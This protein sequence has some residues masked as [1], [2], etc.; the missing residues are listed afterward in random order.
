[1]AGTIKG[2]TI[3]IEG[4]T[5]GLTKSLQE[6]E[7]QIKKD[8]AAL[9]NLEKAL[10]LDPTNVDLLAAKEAVLA[11]KTEAVTKK[12]D[13]LKQV[14]SDALTELPDDAQLTSS[15]MAELATEIAMTEATLND[16]SGASE[17]ASEDMADVGDSAEETGE[18]VEDSS[19]SFSDFGD[20]AE[21]AGEMAAAAMD[22][23]V[24]AVE[25]VVAAA[26][27]AG[28][29]IGAAFVEAGSALVDATFNT[30]Q[31]AD[32]LLTL[33][34]TT[35]L[36]TDTLQELNYA[37]ELL[38]V[39]TQ[40]VTGSMTKLLKTMGNAADG[41]SSAAAK[42][43]EL[44]IAYLDSEGNM[45][46]VEDVFWESIDALGQIENESERDA[47]AMELFGRS[48]RE[49]NPLIEAGSGAFEELAEE[50]NE[51][52]YVMSGETLDAFGELDDNMQ[53][54]NNM[55]DAVS[56]SFGQ[57]L[58]PILSD[59]SGEAV[60]L[61]GDFSGALAATGGD[62]DQIASVIETFAPR[63]VELVEKYIPQIIKIVE[64]VA[65]AILPVI[66]SLAPQLIAML[67]NLITTLANS[68]ADNAE[69]FISAF[70]IL[71]ESVVNSV[72]TLLPVL[73]PLAIDLIM[74][75]VNALIDNA[76]LL[77]EGALGIVMTLCE[78]LLAPEN[79]EQLAM[80]AIEI[81][82]TL[83]NGLTTA[84]PVLIPAALDAI[85][86]LVETL[87]SGDSLSQLIGAA[88]TLITTLA[89]SLI[90]YLPE[91]IARLPEII[92]GIVE[93]LCGDGLQ[94]II[95]AGF[96]L[97][98]ALITNLDDIIVAIVGGLIELVAGMVEYFTGDG[99]D[100]LIK[101]GQTMFDGLINLA[102][103]WGSDLIQQFIDGI[104]AMWESLKGT[105]NSVAELVKNIL[106][107]SVPE[108][109]PLH[110]WAFNN[111]GE[112]M[113]KLWSEG[114][115]NGMSDLQN[116]LNNAALTIDDEMSGLDNSYEVVKRSDIRQTVDYSGGLS[117]IEQAITASVASNGAGLE[118]VTLVI[119]V[120][121]GGDLIDTVVV[122]S[123]DRYNYRAGGRS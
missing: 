38:D 81:V 119:P 121:L 3:Q 51:V 108:E 89:T 91:L 117:R 102:S 20:A 23:V 46:S 6:V 9:K 103:S 60:S 1:M 15:Q 75:L 72:I 13:I 95:E 32:E 62:I 47:A 39:D 8:D 36:S 24:V 111:P 85:M 48:A 90:D 35:G 25:A 45:R 12:M 98:T 54:L 53:R 57:I 101:A 18:D 68:I 44:G 22:A 34:S 42:F 94:Q 43:E 76:P 7:S 97:I 92:L 114:V 58:L 87:L 61:M 64:Q 4:K 96:T 27:A 100:D 99:M 67:G 88:L 104:M 65:N 11:D 120:Y 109:G 28:A 30:S 31:L 74:T 10:Q 78:T 69:S 29:A 118:G 106:G 73:I 2:I 66:I 56:N 122:D 17:E 93:Y 50:A 37:S 14:Q 52:G 49:L 80:S 84:L 115:E 55:T 107:F 83:L 77:L 5:S 21:V 19:D 16:L 71:F 123:L 26:V 63:A 40:T 112:D 110:E 79:I 41:S 59:M 33:S 105:L 116:T 86:T 70:T 113:L 82:T